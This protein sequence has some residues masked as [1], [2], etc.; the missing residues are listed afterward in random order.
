MTDGSFLQ[1]NWSNLKLNIVSF[2]KGKCRKHYF[3]ISIVNALPVNGHPTVIAVDGRTSFTANVN[4][5]FRH[6]P[7]EPLRCAKMSSGTQLGERFRWQGDII[8]CSSIFVSDGQIIGSDSVGARE[9]PVLAGGRYPPPYELFGLT[10]SG[11]PGRPSGKWKFSGPA[12]KLPPDWILFFW[13]RPKTAARPPA[14]EKNSLHLHSWRPLTHKSHIECT[15]P[16]R[17]NQ[18]IRSLPLSKWAIDWGF[19]IK[20]KLP[21]KHEINLEVKKYYKTLISIEVIIFATHHW[22]VPCHSKM[23]LKLVMYF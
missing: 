16:S 19:I 20:V 7:W 11:G 13:T 1:W 8:F 18:Y 4:G 15:S 22:K 9:D 5:P 3:R 12:R 17:S 21:I 23:E 6:F 14:F 2:W 10:D